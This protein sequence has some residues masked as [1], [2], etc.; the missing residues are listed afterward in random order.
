[1]PTRLATAGTRPPAMAPPSRAPTSARQQRRHCGDLAGVSGPTNRHAGAFLDER[2]DVLLPGN[3]VGNLPGATALAVI[4]WAVNSC[5]ITLVS[6]PRAPL[7]AQYADAPTRGAC[8]C[9]LVML[10]IR[11]PWPAARI[12]RAPRWEQ[13]NGP[14]RS[15]ESTSR[16]L[17]HEHVHER[18]GQ[19]A[20]GI[21]DQRTEAA[22]PVGQLVA[23]PGRLRQ[24]GQGPARPPRSGGRCRAPRRRCARRPRVAVPAEVD[25]ETGAR[26]GSV[27]LNQS[28][29]NRPG[30]G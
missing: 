30:P 22:E 28:G 9:T 27:E 2:V 23:H 25:V 7:A 10:M 13:R 16:H 26:P 21:V 17:S 4:P 15:T 19:A 5:A 18:C 8:S 6:S 1:M 14:S 12:R 20:A 11:P 3:R 24:P 29:C